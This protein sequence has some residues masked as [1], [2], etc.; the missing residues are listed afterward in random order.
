MKV[1]LTQLKELR[2]C[3][4]QILLFQETFGEEVEV[5]EETCIAAANAGISIGWTVLN[6]LT[7]AQQKIFENAIAP[8]SKAFYAVCGMLF[9]KFNTACGLLSEAYNLASDAE[10]SIYE[11]KRKPLQDAYDAGY[12]SAYGEYRKAYA[13]AFYNATL[14]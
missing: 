5:T 2:A 4:K 11:A 1:T 9:R 3:K 10:W 6:L 8:S 14:A 7:S 12:N 13:A